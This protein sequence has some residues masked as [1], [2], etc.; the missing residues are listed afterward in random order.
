MQDVLDLLTFIAENMG[1]GEGIEGIRKT[2]LGKGYTENEINLAFNYLFLTSGTTQEVEEKCPKTRILHPIENMLISPEAY[3]HLL[4][5]R[6]LKIIDDTQL[7]RIIEEA[8]METEDIVGIEE[9]KKAAYKVLFQTRGTDYSSLLSE[10][11]EEN[12]PIQ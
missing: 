11:D 8:L 10:K 4:K 12:L 5:L 9:I 2:L 1:K 7:E 3:G 6:V